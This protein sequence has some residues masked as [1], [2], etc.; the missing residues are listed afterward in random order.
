[1]KAARADDDRLLA[2]K[3]PGNV[4]QAEWNNARNKYRGESKNILITNDQLNEI[5]NHFNEVDESINIDVNTGDTVMMGKFKNKKVVVKNIGKDD[6]DMQTINGKKATTFRIPKKKIEEVA[7]EDVSLSSFKEQSKLNDKFWD[8]EKLYPNVR[9]RLLKISDDFLEFLKIDLKFCKDVLFLGSLTNYRWSKYSDVD[10]HIL[11]DFKKINK[12]VEFVRD[13]FDSKKKI[14]NDEH[15]SLKIYNFPVEVYVQDMN[16][17]NA[18]VSLFSL[19]K[20]KWIKKP[21]EKDGD[22][23]NTDKIKEKAS[24]IMTDIDDL[25]EKYESETSDSELKELSNKVIK[26]YD[27]IKKIRKSG[28]AT[29][30]GEMSIGN[31]V[32]KVLRRSDY[33][34]KIVELKALTYD[35]INSIK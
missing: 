11:M 24:G 29:E 15:D 18:S 16:E 7:S 19:E 3:F 28:L 2:N 8:G 23:L 12:D 17:E 6:Y 20:N 26:L 31:I 21:S 9:K 25:Y 10:L 22:I 1:M 14:W 35:K 5:K 27:K 33:I 13:Y 4:S 30:D 34:E 32:F